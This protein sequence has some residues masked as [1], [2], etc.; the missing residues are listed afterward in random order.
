MVTWYDVI[1][2]V[3]K[4]NVCSSRCTH[5]LKSATVLHATN[6]NSALKCNPPEK[7]N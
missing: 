3:A 4:V 6:D 5:S 1:T 2:F 7:K